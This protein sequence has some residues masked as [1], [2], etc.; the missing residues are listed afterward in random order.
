MNRV[1][2][3]KSVNPDIVCKRYTLGQDGTLTKTAVAHVTEGIAK[4][5]DVPDAQEMV[6][7]LNHVTSKPNLV[8]CSGAWNNDPG[9]GATFKVYD[10]RRLATILGSEPGK[11]PGGVIEHQGELI[12]ARL[13][14]GIEPSAWVLLDADNPPGMPEEWAAW[15]IAERLERFESVLPG[16]SKCERIELRGS[17]ARVLNGS[18]SKPTTHAWLRVN[19]PANIALMKAWVG[20]ET[21][22]KGLAF[23]FNKM[24]RVH[25]D[26]VVGVENRTL[27]DL[28]VFDTG[29][30]VFCAQPDIQAPGYTLDDAGIVIVNE[31]G[32]ELDIAWLT[33]P[34]REALSDY[35]AKTGIE[36]DVRVKDGGLSITSLGQLT[37][38]TEI[39]VRGT[40]KTLRE[41]VADMKAGDKLRCESPFRESHSEAAFIRIDDDGKPFV[42]DIGNGVTY[43]MVLLS[44]MKAPRS[45]T[46]DEALDGEVLAADYV[47]DG[48]G[49]IIANAHN[50]TEYLRTQ[51]GFQGIFATD[52]FANKRVLL[53]R[54]PNAKGPRDLKK[55]MALEERHVVAILSHVQRHA[56]PKATKA[57]VYDAL[58]LAFRNITIHP[59]RDY[60]DSLVWDGRPRLSRWLEIYLGAQPE[61]QGGE[62]YLEAVGRAWMI[63]AV[64]RVFKPGCKADNAIILEGAQ[65]IGKST[66][67]SILGGEWFGDNLPHMGT[68]DAS[69]YLQGLWIVE[70][71]ELSNMARAEVEVVKAFMSRTEDRFRPAYARLEIS[72]PRQC[73]FIGSTNQ[74][75]YLK[76]VTG[77]RRFWPVRCGEVHQ[78][79]LKEDRD[80]LWAEAVDAFKAGE[81]WWLNNDV[82]AVAG[83]RQADR[84]DNDDAWAGDV[85]KATEGKEQFGICIAQ[86]MEAMLMEKK[87]RTR[88]ASV[89]IAN[90]LKADGWEQQGYVS[91]TL[92]YGK[93]RRYVRPKG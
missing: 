6:R 74:D 38:D 1:T 80:Q 64:A 53:S 85:L 56:M 15:S 87:D 88:I 42:Y 4:S 89:R 43:R 47:T 16:I 59:V 62:R 31:G 29:R 25:A 46:V 27:F 40:T 57:M 55:P 20:V 71:A 11:V 49:N 86:I 5:V 26:Q 28:A 24:S 39:T 32:G 61:G 2:I 36:L 23:R 82:A 75:S 66:A 22:R 81:P 91:K 37:M 72:V 93:A 33:Q 52:T 21:V 44:D 79:R 10:E 67:A 17:S 9:N 63:A 34:T 50:I 45:D 76:D 3:I 12:S 78:D 35:K 69:S 48:R 77:N 92:G 51:P 70:M 68:K 73:V 18:G 19:K 58:E 13:K 83:E 14:R 30:L 7:V 84:V 90:I 8:M 60:L 41:W 54:L 65:G